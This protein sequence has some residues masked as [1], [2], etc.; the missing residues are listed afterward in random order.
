MQ[1]VQPKMLYSDAGGSMAGGCMI[2]NNKVCE[3]SVFQ[4]NLS[5]EEMLRSSTF[6][7]LRGVEEG[8]KALADKIRGG[9]VR[10]HCDNWAACKIV[11]FG[12]MKEDCHVVAK[13][14]NDLVRRLDVSFNIVWLSRESEEIRFADRIVSVTAPQTGR[15]MSC[16][17]QCVPPDRP[18]SIL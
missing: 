16:L 14:I 1:V 15:A 3:D 7:E 11:E 4:V 8:I 17:S 18:G 13:R 12:S 6:R 10:W 9:S 5:E 2:I